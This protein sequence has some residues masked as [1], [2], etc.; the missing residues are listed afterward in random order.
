MYC[1]GLTYLITYLITYLLTPWS[2]VFL[3]N[4][5]SSQLVK[6]FHAFYGTCGFITA[7]RKTGYLFLFWALYRPII[8]KGIP[9]NTP[10]RPRG[11]YRYSSTLSLTSAL[12][13]V[14]W[15]TPRPSRSTTEKNPVPIVQKAEWASGPVWTVARNFAATLNRSPIRLAHSELP[16][17]RT[18]NI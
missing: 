16:V 17:F 8:G 9:Y 5:T 2:R 1:V 4:L 12:G 14:G 10:C 6:K 18:N 7:F 3:E 13:V 15:S 11:K